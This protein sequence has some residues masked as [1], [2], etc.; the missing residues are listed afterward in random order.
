MLGARETP[1]GSGVGPP[2]FDVSGGFDI[3]QD[4]P[5]CD[6]SSVEG[7]RNSS[8]VS[9]VSNSFIR[10]SEFKSD[11]EMKRASIL[12]DDLQITR[13]G[14]SGRTAEQMNCGVS[15]A[16]DKKWEQQFA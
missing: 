1:P 15:A 2:P 7:L 4:E 6:S 9:G 8:S 16:V 12:F 3:D 5:G 13:R 14:L 11:S 10:A